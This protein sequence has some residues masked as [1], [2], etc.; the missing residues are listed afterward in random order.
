MKPRTY[1]L[2]ESYEP[3]VNS[4]HGSFVREAGAFAHP[5]VQET[6][7]KVCPCSMGIV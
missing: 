2:Q 7:G 4:G 1:L 3:H 5:G 6:L